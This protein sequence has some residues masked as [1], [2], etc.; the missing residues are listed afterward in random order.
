VHSD[1]CGGKPAASA[2]S[3]N[4]V[5]LKLD[6]RDSSGASVVRLD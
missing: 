5:V 2:A 3:P 6:D 1:A 4:D